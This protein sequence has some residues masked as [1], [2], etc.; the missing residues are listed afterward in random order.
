MFVRAVFFICDACCIVT[1]ERVLGFSLSL[2]L[3]EY[4]Q[5]AFEFHQTDWKCNMS[6]KIVLVAMTFT[7][8]TVMY[9]ESE[10]QS[11]TLR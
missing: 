1:N 3:A 7:A 6:W 9:T 11:H 2:I 4:R 8:I 5:L 10:D